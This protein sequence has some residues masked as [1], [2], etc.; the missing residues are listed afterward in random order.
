MSFNQIRYKRCIFFCVFAILQRRSIRFGG[1]ARCIAALERTRNAYL[2]GNFL[3]TTWRFFRFTPAQTKPNIFVK[4][5]CFRKMLV[6][7]PVSI[8]HRYRTEKSLPA[9]GHILK[10]LS[11]QRGL[12][13]ISESKKSFMVVKAIFSDLDG[14]QNVFFACTAVFLHTL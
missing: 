13:I 6:L 8:F 3:P 1:F 12:Q 11:D 14:G 5:T 4:T 2:G 7:V 10:K 9:T